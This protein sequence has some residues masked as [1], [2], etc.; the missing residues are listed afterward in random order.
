MGLEQQRLQQTH[1]TG[2]EIERFVAIFKENYD[3]VVAYIENPS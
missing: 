3:D 2:G 1:L